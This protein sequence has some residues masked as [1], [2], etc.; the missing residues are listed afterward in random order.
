MDPAHVEKGTAEGREV[1]VGSVHRI[2]SFFGRRRL[3]HPMTKPEATMI[4]LERLPYSADCKIRVLRH[5]RYGA[6]T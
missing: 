6:F 3:A 2:S 5:R 1:V 4:G